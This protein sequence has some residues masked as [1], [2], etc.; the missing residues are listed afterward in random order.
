[1]QTATRA[2]PAIVPAE[3]MT[4]SDLVAAV[5]RIRATGVSTAKEVLASLER[6]GVRV[7]LPEVRKACSK[8]AKRMANEDAARVPPMAE[9]AYSPRVSP[10]DDSVCQK[11]ASMGL[12]DHAAERQSV[13]AAMDE[14]VRKQNKE[15]RQI[16]REGL[17]VLHL[18]GTAFGFVGAGMPLPDGVPANFALKQVAT[19][20]FM[21]GWSRSGEGLGNMKSERLYREY[22]D[23]LVAERGTWLAFFEHRGNYQHAEN[24]C[25]IL[26]TL[27]TIYR[28]RGALDECERVLDMEAEV[29]ARYERCS[30]GTEPAQVR[31]CEDL[32]YKYRVIRYNLCLQRG[33]FQDCIALYR[34]LAGHEAR[35][36]FSFEES[37]FLFM[38]AV[39]LNKPP[40]AA[41]LGRLSA[42]QV[43]RIVK[44]P[45]E[46]P[47][48]VDFQDSRVQ[49][50]TCSTCHAQEPALRTFKPCGRCRAVYYCGKEC[51]RMDWKAGHKERCQEPSDG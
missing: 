20:A 29:L 18:S 35:H 49:L 17:P 16:R 19:M 26:G 42:A 38:I 7:T 22:F 14:K 51:Q 40:T 25:G 8:A 46:Q 36:D 6:E 9:G 39:I 24:T 11:L 41:V 31:C 3:A 13:D 43:L 48:G 5:T 32:A 28:K 1:M 34:E 45:L 47:G 27:A 50:Q 37:N 21:E 4:E 33:H 10:S 15:H 2:L 30:I 44:A 12:S 23:E